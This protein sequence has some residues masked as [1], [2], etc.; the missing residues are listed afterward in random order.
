MRVIEQMTEAQERMLRGMETAQEQIIDVNRRVVEAMSNRLGE[1]DRLSVPTLPGSE[2]LPQ[3]DEF[4][5][6]YFDFTAKMA[7]ANRSFYKEMVS[8]WVPEET[9]TASK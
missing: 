2:S 4:I 7:E 8:I 9:K 1:G 6:R 5:D 3:P